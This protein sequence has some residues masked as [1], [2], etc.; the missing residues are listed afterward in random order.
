[1][2]VWVAFAVAVVFI[3]ACVAAAVAMIGEDFAVAQRE[4]L[5]DVL[6]SEGPVAL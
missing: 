5:L 1:M 2:I 4:A 3:V 6:W